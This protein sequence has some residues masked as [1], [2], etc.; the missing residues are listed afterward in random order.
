MKRTAD[1]LL[2]LNG[3]EPR[4]A[5][6]V[7]EIVGALVVTLFLAL[8]CATEAERYATAPVWAVP[9][10]RR[11]DLAR[12]RKRALVRRSSKATAARQ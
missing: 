12:D 11:R 8:Y 3:R 7:V 4:V 9:P 2:A 5:S 1:R 10:A 6:N